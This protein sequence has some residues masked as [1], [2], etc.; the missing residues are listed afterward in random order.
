MNLEMVALAVLETYWPRGR[1][2]QDRFRLST[3]LQQLLPPPG[4]IYGGIRQVRNHLLLWAMW[5]RGQYDR[6]LEKDTLLET[7]SEEDRPAFVRTVVHAHGMVELSRGQVL[8]AVAALKRATHLA[9]QGQLDRGLL[10][11]MVLAW[12]LEG[13]NKGQSDAVVEWLSHP[14]VVSVLEGSETGQRDRLLALSLAHLQT[15]RYGQART[16]LDELIA[17]QPAEV[18]RVQARYIQ[19]LSM[20]AETQTWETAEAEGEDDKTGDMQVQAMWRT[21]RS[22]LQGM[23][24]ELSEAPPEFAWRGH[25]LLGLIAYV[26]SEATP[27]MAQ[28]E[29]FGAAIEQVDSKQAQ[30]SLQAVE[31]VLL[32]RARATDEAIGYVQRRAYAELRTL[33]D[34]VL[35]PLGDAVPAMVRA[36]VFITLWE[37]NPAY[38]PLPDLHTIPLPPDPEDPTTALVT[39]CMEQVRAVATLKQLGA[40]C[41]Q[42]R[43]GRNTRLPSLAPL[44]FD[45]GAAQMGA[46]AVAVLRLRRGDWPGALDALPS[47]PAED[48]PDA[49]DFRQM[50]YYVRVYSAWKLGDLER[51]QTAGPNRFL[52]RLE[53]WHTALKARRLMAALEDRDEVLALQLLNY[54]GTPDTLVEPLTRTTGWLLER[55]KPQPA[56]TFLDTVRR[57]VL[58]GAGTAQPGASRLTWWLPFLTGMAAAQ[59]GQYTASIES[60]DRFQAHPVPTGADGE[61]VRQLQGLSKLFKLEAELALVVQSEEDL[62]TRWP[63]VRRSLAEQAE[64]LTETPELRAYGALVSG[65]VSYLTA[66]TLTDQRTVDNLRAAQRALPVSRHGRF[67][68]SVLGRLRWRQNVLMDFWVGIH[69]GDLKE[70]RGIYQREIKPVFGDR[71]PYSIQLGMVIVDWDAGAVPTSELLKR[72]TIL[73][74]EATELN[75][76]LIQQVRKYVEEADQTRRFTELVRKRDY[77]GVIS[78]ISRSSW[79]ESMPVPVAIALLHAY[80]R[81]KR[82][83]DAKRFGRIITETP[84]LAPWVRDYGYFILGYLRYDNKEYEEAAQAFEKVRVSRLLEK[85]DTDRYW[86]ASWHARGLQYLEGGK[87]EQREQAFDCFRRSLGQ[88]GASAGNVSLAPLFTYFGLQNLEAKKGNRAYQAFGLLKES[89]RGLEDSRE[90]VRSR[91]LAEMGLLLC[92]SLWEKKEGDPIP[93]GKDFVA[94]VERVGRHR[95]TLKEVERVILQHTICRMAICQELRKERQLTPRRRMSKGKLRR[96]V[97]A[98]VNQLEQLSRGLGGH[99]PVVLVLKGLM[100]IHLKDKRDV[101]KGLEYLMEAARLGFTSQRFRELVMVLTELKRRGLRSRAT[102]VDLFDTYL[103]AGTLPSGWRNYLQQRGDIARLYRQSRGYAP[104][105][106]ARQYSIEASAVARDRVKHVKKLIKD[107][108]LGKEAEIE[109]LLD[110]LDGLVRELKAAEKALDEQEKKVMNAVAGRIEKA[111]PADS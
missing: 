5:N 16:V 43:L 52:D 63:S 42:R 48:Q 53:G 6:I 66:D 58:G 105:E 110:P 24:G 4:R 1:T 28:V 74:H 40:L 90:V 37:G 77:D 20:L 62:A 45:Q 65:L 87:E 41:G 64:R 99:D 107:S 111:T 84:R 103:H 71:V 73:E 29:Q 8:G 75:P 13:L 57:E 96:F 89:V 68:E 79:A 109:T 32:T 25:L 94:L 95:G 104:Q 2:E 81:K 7:V 22:R 108:G 51:C 98:Q 82:H 61:T 9:G 56:L 14:E 38:D 80:Y 76:A 12:A 3:S 83:E 100:E 10:P 30:R 36:A 97:V 15:G 88:R 93:A 86:A 92:D 49:N 19:G 50:A 44:H 31:G 39:S 67:L 59:A 72:L 17:V 47:E 69:R 102:A 33:Q 101:S 54:D 27:S 34:Q 21:L 18:T 23:V 60:F 46:L 26:D 78:F 70:S 106:V 35:E 11:T 85:H 55:R 91:L